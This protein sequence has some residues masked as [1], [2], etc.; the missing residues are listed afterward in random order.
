MSSEI[1]AFVDRV[2]AIGGDRAMYF[3]LGNAL[4]PQNIDA[5]QLQKRAIKDGIELTVYSAVEQALEDLI[6]KSPGSAGMQAEALANRLLNRLQEAQVTS[7]LE[8]AWAAAMR[9]AD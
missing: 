7:A 4:Y 1:Q 8:E 5:A 9:S 3:A 6:P 2:K